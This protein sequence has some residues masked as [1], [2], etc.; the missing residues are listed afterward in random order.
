MEKLCR[1]KFT[2]QSL[3]D[4]G[5]NV[6]EYNFS[7]IS[8]TE[9]PENERYHRSAPSGKLTLCVTNPDI[10]FEPRKNYYLDIYK[11]D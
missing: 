3:T 7:P 5:N 2:C 8:S 1:G 6:K 10:K 4:F 9:T 11:A